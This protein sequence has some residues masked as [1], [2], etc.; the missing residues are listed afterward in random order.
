MIADL[1]LSGTVGLLDFLTAVRPIYIVGT[2]AGGLVATVVPPTFGSADIFSGFATGP[3]AN[4]V[5]VDTGQLPAGNYDVIA[6]A[7]LGSDSSAG[8]FRLEHRNAANAANLATWPITR[9]TGA[10]D[11][12]SLNGMFPLSM[13]YT[14]AADERLR[15]F[16]TFI[17]GASGVYT[18]TIMAKIVAVP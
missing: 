4:T 18:A 8:E 6:M 12:T 14:L 5:I 2:R 7:A 1:K 17:S 15:F 16:T 10:A 3:A 9:R 13:R 11:G